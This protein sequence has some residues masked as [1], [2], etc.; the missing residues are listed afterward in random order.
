MYNTSK[1]PKA[2]F[3]M[4]AISETL[5]QLMQEDKYTNITISQICHEADVVRSSFYR[6]F[7]TKDDIMVYIFDKKI[8]DLIEYCGDHNGDIYRQLFF[9][10]WKSQ[11]EF[12]FLLE[13]H[14]LFLIFIKHFSDFLALGNHYYL[15]NVVSKMPKEWDDYFYKRVSYSTISF[16]EVWTQHKFTESIEELIQIS[17]M[18]SMF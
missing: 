18:T 2:V 16:L 8:D 9:E 1:N 13:E 4:N 14:D 11:S 12:L 3:S 5:L 7:A 17:E 15:N 10:F 6:N